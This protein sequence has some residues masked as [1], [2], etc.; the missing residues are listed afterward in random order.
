MGEGGTRGLGKMTAL[1]C[2]EPVRQRCVI[3]LT[4][5][6]EKEASTSKSRFLHNH[7]KTKPMSQSHRS[8]SHS[9]TVKFGEMSHVCIPTDTSVHV[10]VL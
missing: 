3:C 7:W 5:L 9:Y 2:K 1:I 10:C 6:S 4:T 8:L